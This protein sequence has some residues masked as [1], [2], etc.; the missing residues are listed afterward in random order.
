MPHVDKRLSWPK[1]NIHCEEDGSIIVEGNE[2]CEIFGVDG[3][4]LKDGNGNLTDTP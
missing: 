3:L 4:D 2:G 1:C